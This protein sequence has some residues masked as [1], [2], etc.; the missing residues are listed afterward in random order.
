MLIFMTRCIFMIYV[1]KGFGKSLV[2]D[3]FD[4]FHF[5]VT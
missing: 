1:L 3:V 5:V 2:F 4:L